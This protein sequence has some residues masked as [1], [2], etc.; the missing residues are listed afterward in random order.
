MRNRIFEAVSD[1]GRAD[2]ATTIRNLIKLGSDEDRSCEQREQLINILPAS[3]DGN[4]GV[5]LTRQDIRNLGESGM[6]Y[7]SWLFDR[8]LGLDQDENTLIGRFENLQHDFLQIMR[9]LDVAEA[10]TLN[11]AMDYGKRK[12]TSR[13]SHYSHYYD[14]ELRQLVASEELSLIERFD[15]RFE[16][17]GPKDAQVDAKSDPATDSQQE[18]QKLLGRAENFLLL[19]NNGFDIGPLR[20]KV[21][22]ISDDQWSESDRKETFLRPSGY[23]VGGIDSI[24]CT[25][26]RDSCKA[27]ALCRIRRAG[28]ASHRAY[29]RLLSGQWIRFADSSR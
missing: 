24:R 27:A 11:W 13:H 16:I 22:Q 1:G 10:D 25:F 26:R 21:Q 3:L 17:V 12:N 5:G 4:R 28:P 20:E 29:R 2:F 8:M 7:Y 15:Y 14:E 9:Q 23:P 19:V 18:F 6:G